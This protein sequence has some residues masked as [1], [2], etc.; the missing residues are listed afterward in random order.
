MAKI[1]HHNFLNTIHEVFTDAKQEGVPAFIGMDYAYRNDFSTYR[2]LLLMTIERAIAL[3]FSKIDMGM[4][5]SFEKKKLGAQVIKKYAYLQTA[6]NYTLEL[7]GIME[8]Q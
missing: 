7:L 2:L 1:K 6:D 4:T 5:A 3:G 8:G